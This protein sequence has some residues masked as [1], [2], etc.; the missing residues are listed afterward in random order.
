[1]TNVYTLK[2]TY[3]DCPDKIWREIKISSNYQ[4][5]KLCIAVLV[6]FNTDS[7]HLFNISCKGIT[8]EL[9]VDI[10]F[11]KT[12]KNILPVKLKDLELKIGDGLNMIYDFGCDHMFDMVVTGIESMGRGQGTAYPKVIDGEGRGI[13][14]D[15]PGDELAE[16]IVETDKTGESGIYW[17]GYN[18]PIMWDY[19][20]YDI[21]TDNCL[22]KGQIY[23][24]AD[25]FGLE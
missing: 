15:I 16:I 20:D 13:L 6:S 4:L 2:I 5:V 14:E 11:T 17:E 10:D 19:K 9:P 18:G 23:L 8:Y 21:K 7:C 22:L 25:N 24:I 1:M 12:C 3:R